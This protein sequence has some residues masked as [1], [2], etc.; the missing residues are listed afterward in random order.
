[1]SPYDFDF[2]LYSLGTEEVKQLIFEE[3]LL[4]HD[5]E[6]VEE[7]LSNRKEHPNGILYKRF[8]KNRMR[9]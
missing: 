5:E 9:N 4:H 7:Y 6:A 8:G 1:V 3:I 2:E